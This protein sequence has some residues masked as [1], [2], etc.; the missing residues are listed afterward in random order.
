AGGPAWYRAN[1]TPTPHNGSTLPALALDT[2]GLSKGVAFINGYNLGRY[3]TATATGKAVGP[4]TVF[5]IPESWIKPG[6]ENEVMLF[7]EHGFSPSG[8]RVVPV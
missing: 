5:P 8:V 6:A 2:H 4:Q 1:F 7:D 3:F